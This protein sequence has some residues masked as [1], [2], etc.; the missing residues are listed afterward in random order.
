MAIGRNFEEALQKSLRM[1]GTG[2]HGLVLNRLEFDD[3]EE[4]LINPTHRRIFAVGEAL[5]RGETIDRIHDLTKIDRWFLS[6]LK[7]RLRS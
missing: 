2:M 4:E 5:K 6:G 1:I 3:I 7:T